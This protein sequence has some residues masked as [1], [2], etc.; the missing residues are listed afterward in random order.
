MSVVQIKDFQ[1]AHK[2]NL[3]QNMHNGLCFIKYFK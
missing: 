3:K 1:T 2:T